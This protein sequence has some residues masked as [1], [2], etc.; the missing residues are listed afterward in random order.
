MIKRIKQAADLEMI[1]W[2]VSLMILAV[3]N[4]YS[5]SHFSICPLHNLGFQFCP[6][7]G[8]GHSVSFLLHGQIIE[9]LHAHPLGIFALVVLSYRIGQ[10][11]IK[12]INKFKKIG[13]SNV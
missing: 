12:S 10:L 3:I 1:I 6:G 8:L 7:C 9:S 2:I 11:F 13:E 4:P 5:S